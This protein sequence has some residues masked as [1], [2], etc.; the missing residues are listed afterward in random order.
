VKQGWVLIVLGIAGA[1]FLQHSDAIV[2]GVC[3]VLFGAWVLTI[4]EKKA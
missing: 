1:V 2:A 3:A 4:K